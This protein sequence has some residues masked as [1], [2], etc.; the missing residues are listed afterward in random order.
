MQR[1]Q[2][3]LFDFDGVLADTEPIHFVCWAQVLRP[4]GID[5]DWD[6][7]RRHG[8]G[9]TDLALLEFLARQA[10]PHRERRDPTSCDTA[11]TAIIRAACA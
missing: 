4:L 8:V 5:L 3:I 1:Y 10:V 6:T 11:E 9:L 2:A 7:F